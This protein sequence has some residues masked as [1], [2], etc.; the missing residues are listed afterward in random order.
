MDTTITCPTDDD[1]ILNCVDDSGLGAGQ[2]QDATIICPD[3]GLCTVKCDGVGNVCSGLTINNI[4]HASF[5]CVGQNCPGPYSSAPT[6]Y[7]NLF[8]FIDLF[9]VQNYVFTFQSYNGTNKNIS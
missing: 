7:D 9:D 8:K 2:C 6:T 5:E 3:S 4:T 1:C